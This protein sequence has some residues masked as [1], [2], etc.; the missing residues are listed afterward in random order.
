MKSGCPGVIVS[1]VKPGSPGYKAGLRRGDIVISA[2]GESISDS[3]EFTFF[4]AQPR[5]TLRILRGNAGRDRVMVRSDG[6]PSGIQFRDAPIGRCGNRCI[7]C[8]I[9]QMPRGL[10]KS[11]YIKDEDYRHSFANG[12]YITLSGASRTLLRRI[13][14]LGLSPLYISVHATDRKVRRTLLGNDRAFD[15]MPQ[16]RFLESRGVRFHTQIVVCPGINDGAVLTRTIRAL[17][18][19]KG[20]L[21]IAV[22]PVGLTRHRSTALAGVDARAAATILKAVEPLGDR[23]AGRDG[24]RRIFCADELFIK[25]DAAIPKTAY[26]EDYPQIENGVGLVRQLLDEWKRI[27]KGLPAH[28]KKHRG[29]APRTIPLRFLIVTSVSAQSFVRAIMNELISLIPLPGISIDVEAIPNSF[30]GVTVT[31]A[32]LLTARDVLKAISP[33]AS[34]YS[35]VFLPEVMFN[36]R[37]YTLDGYSRKRI[38]KQLGL[39]VRT[40]SGIGELVEQILGR[41][42]GKSG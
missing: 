6:C 8:F 25:A 21:S 42:A 13:A 20:L 14:V 38:E 12:N 24:I 39:P 30:F 29:S 10:R 1:R 19:L 40:V 9:D 37:G 32:G 23:Q 34:G 4:T 3:L 33:V 17:L 15:I 31:V 28:A 27:K 26:Y 41:Y 35:R 11:L 18:T 7:F 16:L 5:T 36:T 2:G 22:V